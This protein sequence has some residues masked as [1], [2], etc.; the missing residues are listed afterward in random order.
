VRLRLARRLRRR[1][2]SKGTIGRLLRWGGSGKSY[3]SAM[4]YPQVIFHFDWFLC[5]PLH[6]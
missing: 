5:W 1:L 4:R 2:M 6:L 3:P